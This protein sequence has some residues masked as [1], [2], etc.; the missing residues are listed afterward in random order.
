MAWYWVQHQSI[1]KEEAKK[2]IMA[3]SDFEDKIYGH[4]PDRS[5]ADTARLMKEYTGYQSVWVRLNIGAKDIE[6]ELLKDNL[7]IVPING[8]ILKN[9]FYTAP[10]PEHHMVVVI[11]YDAQKDEFITNDIGTCHGAKYRYAASRLESS[12]QDY[13]TGDHLPAAPGATAMI[14]V[15]PK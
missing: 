12:L 10:G 11:G 5:A 8:R 14:V 1:I 4:A 3:I 7:V 2:E 15:A 13:P 6:E 9:P